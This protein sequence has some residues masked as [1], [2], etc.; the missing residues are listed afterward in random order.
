MSKAFLP[1]TDRFDNKTNG[2][3]ADSEIQK[4]PGNATTRRRVGTLK[5]WNRTS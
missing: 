2:R 5:G 1:L 3:K 4:Q